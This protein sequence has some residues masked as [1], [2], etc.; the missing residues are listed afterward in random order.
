MLADGD[1]LVVD[2]ER[3]W[4]EERVGRDGFVK[5]LL[6]GCVDGLDELRGRLMSS[7]GARRRERPCG[8]VDGVRGIHLVA[9]KTFFK[10]DDAVVQSGA[11]KEDS[12]QPPSSLALAPRSTLGVLAV[13]GGSYP[14]SLGTGTSFL[15]R[16]ELQATR[17]PRTL[18]RPQLRASPPAS[19]TSPPAPSR[20]LRS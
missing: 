8:G 6:G 7:R 4:W 1:E 17:P 19:L 12:E 10:T 3:C 11:R 16:H 5:G 2:G 9:V 15:K 14:F 20:A 13:C 18:E